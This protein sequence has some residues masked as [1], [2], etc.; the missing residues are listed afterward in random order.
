MV[1]NDGEDAVRVYAGSADAIAD[2]PLAQVTVKVP[3]GHDTLFVQDLTGD[4]RVEILVWG[5]HQRQG[6]LLRLP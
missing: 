5:P 3:P 1:S 2:T 6:I 4:G